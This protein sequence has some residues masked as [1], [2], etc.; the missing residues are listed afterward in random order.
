MSH[1]GESSVV[2][3]EA[4]IATM[5]NSVQTPIK[6]AFTSDGDNGAMAMT[7]QQDHEIGDAEEEELMDTFSAIKVSY[8]GAL[9]K[10]LAESG[11]IEGSP[12]NPGR[13][14]RL[15]QHPTPQKLYDAAL[16]TTPCP[17]NVTKAH[18]SCTYHQRDHPG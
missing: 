16:G 1:P 2:I 17:P 13:Y 8:H 10:R 11:T 5:N 6:P 7:P 9:S 3:A 15:D 12:V 14:K 18:S 4:S